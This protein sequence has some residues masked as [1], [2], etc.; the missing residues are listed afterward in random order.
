MNE[1]KKYVAQLEKIVSQSGATPGVTIARA[2]R[3]KGGGP[4]VRR[5]SGY[6]GIAFIAES[7]FRGRAPTAAT[8]WKVIF[9]IL[10]F[11]GIS[12]GLFFVLW[13]VQVKRREKRDTD[14]HR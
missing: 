13:Y 5:P 2:E 12:G 3:L 7:I 1:T 9:I 8:T 11:V 4:E 14:D 10:G 6:E